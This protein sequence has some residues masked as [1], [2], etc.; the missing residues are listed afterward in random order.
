[1]K[2]DVFISYSSKDIEVALIVCK[3]L[4]E[5]D[6]KCWMAPI[7]IPSGVEYE[8]LVVDAI[9]ASKVFLFIYSFGSVYS[10]WCKMELKVAF[11]EKKTIISYKSITNKKT[12]SKKL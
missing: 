3:M 8:D 6:I 11:S 5:H 2:Y 12:N 10:D 7:N 1:M 9:I 4:E